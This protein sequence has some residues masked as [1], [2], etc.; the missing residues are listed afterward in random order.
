MTYLEFDFVRILEQGEVGRAHHVLCDFGV[1]EEI[2][3]SSIDEEF[4]GVHRVDAEQ[5]GL[6]ET[7]DRL[8][9]G[10]DSRWG[11]LEHTDAL[12]LLSVLV[13]LTAELGVDTEVLALG[14]ALGVLFALL[15][16]GD[17]D[18]LEPG[19]KKEEKQ[20]QSL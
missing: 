13:P 19:K 11:E 3:E 17:H 12:L 14:E 1:T 2:S 10:V 15:Q 18:R 20:H 5:V 9:V 7:R 16:V 8:S 4:P 6:R